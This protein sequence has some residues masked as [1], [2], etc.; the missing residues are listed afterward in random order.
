MAAAVLAFVSDF[1]AA[2]LHLLE[3]RL[4]PQ[5]MR[6]IGGMLWLKVALS[7]V[8]VGYI[9]SDTGR[10]LHSYVFGEEEEM[11]QQF[12]SV[13]QLVFNYL[14]IT[15]VGTSLI[16]ASELLLLCAPTRR[17]GIVLQGRIVGARKNWERHPLR[18]LVEVT[19]TFGATTLYCSTTKDMLLSLQLGTCCGVLLILSSELLASASRPR[20][21]S[22]PSPQAAVEMPA[23]HWV[24][25]IP[26]VVMMLYFLFQVYAAIVR[27][28]IFIAVA[29]ITLT[30]LA[31]SGRKP[32]LVELARIGR[33]LAARICVGIITL[34]APKVSYG[35]PGVLF[36]CV[37]SAFCIAFSRECWDDIEVNEGAQLKEIACAPPQP[38]DIP[39]ISTESKVCPS[40]S[41]SDRALSFVKERYP[42]LYKRVK[43]TFVGIMV[44]STLDMC[45]TFFAVI[46]QDKLSLSQFSAINVVVSASV[47]YLT[48]PAPYELHPAV[49]L[50]TGVKQFKNKWVVFPLHM[51]VETLVFVGVFVGT[52]AASSTVFS[53]LTLA[54]LSGIVVSVG[55]HWVC[56]RLH[57]T[58]GTHMRMQLTAT[59]ELQTLKRTG[60]WSPYV[61][62]GAFHMVCCYCGS[63]ALYDDLV[64]ALQLGTFS[65][66][67]V[68]LSG[69]YFRKNRSKL[70]PWGQ[71][72]LADDEVLA[73]PI[74]PIGTPCGNVAEPT[75]ARPLPVMLL[76]AYIG[77][78][79]FQWIFENMRSLEVTVLLATIAGIAFLCFADMLVLF[80]P[81]R[82]AGVILQ[83]RFINV[84]QNWRGY[85]VR[86]FV[87]FGCFMGVIYGSYAIYQDLVVAVQVGTL[88]GMLVTLGGEQLRNCARAM[89]LNEADRQEVEKTQ[90]LPLP[91]MSLLGLVGA[92]A[93]NIIYTHLRSIEVAFVLATTSGVI[94]ALVGDMFVIWKPTRKVGMVLQERILYFKQNFSSHTRRSWMEVA[95]LCGG[96]YL[97]Y[98]FLWPGD[99]LIAIQFG[100]TT[101]I[102]ACVCGELTMEYVA[103]AERRLIAGVSARLAQE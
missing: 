22:P 103:E 14:L 85:P 39:S 77:S 7:Y 102:V 10:K 45:S 1:L 54:A 37:L 51:F 27:A 59:A 93:F 21:V 9:I 64:L 38:A 89:P 17:A 68:T 19:G 100:T 36:S 49:L 96:W 35:L 101:G 52:F 41:W 55:G 40:E 87:E 44:V 86:S 53:S 95:S 33:R 32:S 13:D 20:F 29:A 76:F 56:S 23:D 71:D 78:G 70:I 46:N 31:L 61:L 97:S 28:Q 82:W 90:I 6:G 74:S 58:V 83:D 16:I 42:H 47:G 3:T 34:V 48:S 24:K 11:Q 15:L 12:Q 88:S 18:S 43:W 62:F 60:D 26:V 50:N 79:T 98:D 84:K 91:V 25:L 8:C 65:G 69:E 92:V 99:L 94:F 66:I 72:L 2:S 81:T 30:V 4:D 5:Q 73:A 80:K 63:F 67:A 57:L 75:R